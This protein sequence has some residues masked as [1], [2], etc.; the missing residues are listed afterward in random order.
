MNYAGIDVSKAQLDCKIDG[1]EKVIRLSNSRSGFRRLVK[2]LR[3]SEVRTV[4]LEAT[5]GYERGVYTFL[6]ASGIPVALLNPRQTNAFARSLGRRAKSDSLD[7][8]ILLEF[9]KRNQPVPNKPLSDDV[10]ILRKLLTRRQ[11]LMKMLV[12]EKNHAKAPGT[13]PEVRK[14]IRAV[15]R[16]LQNQRKSID[17]A[18]EEVIHSN[19]ELSEKSRLLSQQT[20][21]GP[22]LITTLLADMP[23]LGKLERNQASALVGVAPYDRDSGT[24]KGKRAIAGGRV[25]VRNTLYM[26]TLAAIRHNPVLKEFYKRLV[27]RGKPRKVA[28]VACM[29]KFIVYLNGVLKEHPEQHFMAAN[30]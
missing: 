26:A 10:F 6:W 29:R 9:A 25:R 14:S 23:E 2:V 7:A 24:F 1:L 30:G 17:A 18:I 5:G 27:S 19:Q 15:I 28:I 8:E 12:A 4:V 22:V 13:S 11:Q 20:G 3:K 21:V 16:T